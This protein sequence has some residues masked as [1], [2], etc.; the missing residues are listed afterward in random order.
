MSNRHDP[1]P[2]PG[3]AIGWR[4]VRGPSLLSGTELVHTAI[5]PMDDQLGGPDRLGDAMEMLQRLRQPGMPIKDSVAVLT[6]PTTVRLLDRANHA[7]R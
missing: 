2:N 4:G 1:P 5:Q 3:I 7:I 6:G